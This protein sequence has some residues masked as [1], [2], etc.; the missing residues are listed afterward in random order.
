MRGETSQCFSPGQPHPFLMAPPEDATDFGKSRRDCSPAH[1]FQHPESCSQLL[2]DMTLPSSRVTWNDFNMPGVRETNPAALLGHHQLPLAS[3]NWLLG[4][5][6]LT[7]PQG[8]GSAARCAGS[9]CLPD[10]G[11]GGAGLM[12]TPCGTALQQ[13]PSLCRHHSASKKAKRQVK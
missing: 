1:P 10:L 12:G 7:A 9:Q 13:E 11:R 8:A 3:P 6:P 5:V 2:A 4:S